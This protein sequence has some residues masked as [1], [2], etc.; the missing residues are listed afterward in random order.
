MNYVWGLYLFSLVSGF[1]FESSHSIT[2]MEQN[3]LTKESCINNA[4]LLNSMPKSKKQV[5]LDEGIFL[6]YI[7]IASIKEGKIL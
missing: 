1:G 7:C 6:R 3:F 4:K 2:S 5:G